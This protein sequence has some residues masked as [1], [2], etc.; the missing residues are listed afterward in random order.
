M[1]PHAIAVAA[2]QLVTP[3]RVNCCDMLTVW[4]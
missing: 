1:N 2:S 4:K 3:W